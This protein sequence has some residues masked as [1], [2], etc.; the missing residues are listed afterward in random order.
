MKKHIKHLWL[1]AL[2]CSTLSMQAQFQL[3]GFVT[4]QND[5]PLADAHIKLSK[6]Q[7]ATATNSRGRFV[8]DDIPAG[9]YV[10]EVSF[11]GFETHTETIDLTESIELTIALI[12]TPIKANE[13]SVTASRADQK[14]PV[15]YTTVSQKNIESINL[16]QD[17]PELLQNQPSMVFTSDAGN[18][19]G[20]SYLRLR[21]ADQTSINVTINGIPVNDGES[22][23]V[24][25][26]DLPDIASS[27]S[28]IQ[29]QRGVGLSTQG[30]GAFGGAINLIT[31]D[32][33]ADPYAEIN[34]SAG[35]FN[36]LKTTLKLGTG[37]IDDKWL[38]NGRFSALSSDGYMDRSNT[39]LMSYFVS[40]GYFG[41]KTTVK[42]I[43]F[44]A[45]EITKQAW[46]GVPRVRLENDTA[47]MLNYALVSGWGPSKTDLLLQSDRRYN[48]YTW[49]NEV[50][51]YTQ[52]NNQLLLTQTISDYLTLNAALHYTRGYGFFEQYQ[53]EE[54]A[55]D[56]NTFST[57][58]IPNPI[59][60][61]DTIQTAD[62]IRQRW[63][64]NHFAGAV[65]H[66][67]YDKARWKLWMGGGYNQYHGQHYGEVIWSSVATT[68]DVPFRYYDNRAVKHDGNAFGRAQFL[69]NEKLSI[70]GDLQYRGIRYE[71]EGPD[72]NGQATD[73]V[74]SF[75]F[76]NPKIGLNYSL[77]THHQLFGSLA[78][79]NKE[80]N[81]DDFII[82]T[83][84]Q[85]PKH[86]TLV[87]TELGYRYRGQKF[88]I[89]AIGYHMQYTNQLVQTGEL[90]DVGEE[91]RTNVKD[92]YRTGLEL[93]FDWI[94]IKQ[95]E[96]Q[97]NATLSQNK[98]NDHVA[99]I[100]N[101]DTGQKDTLRLGQTNLAFSPEL[102][103]GSQL[104]YTILNQTKGTTSRKL[105]LSLLSKLVGDQYLDN[106]SDDSRKLDA[107]FIN[108]LKLNYRC[109]GRFFKHLEIIALV[110]NVFDIKYVSNGWV[111]T[112]NYEGTTQQ[113]DGLFPQA[114]ANFLI[115]LNLGF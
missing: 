95:I 7:K 66:V 33:I 86:Q 98:I 84:A 71:F 107:Y 56:D 18:G 16:G 6:K 8:F 81:R 113:I 19:I 21:G 17:M 4:D 40:G 102:I 87:D 111:Y 13:F 52:L 101:W 3:S 10:L 75:H 34:L 115:G 58:G 91:I 25:W 37:L 26:V 39:N 53:Y 61:E 55:F 9:S 99:Y 23:N 24:F 30:A 110:R 92:S 57:Y 49:Q 68:Y 60:G 104:T 88:S 76:F 54:N 48:Y 72:E 2:L 65:A 93:V 79:G 70:L 50:D 112:Y 105:D 28:N 97:A 29:I 36:T 46:N 47:G 63:L 44:G 108:D 5:E 14:I 96:W 22:Q 94:P 114:Q 15:A 31:N 42:L 12:Y 109:T 45:H 77:N 43:S 38:F 64:D 106:T 83:P 90:N 51:D 85:R 67:K 89:E 74:I 20:Y 69:I 11:L 1:L 82:S 80:P 41:E 35:S 62:F 73:Q 100:D 59:I 78:V 27:A 32:F 103:L